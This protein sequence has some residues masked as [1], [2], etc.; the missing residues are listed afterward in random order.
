MAKDPP[1]AFDVS[2]TVEFPSQEVRRTFPIPFLGTGHVAPPLETERHCSLGIHILPW[3]SFI[4]RWLLGLKPTEDLT[5]AIAV[6]GVAVTFL[7]ATRARPSALVWIFFVS[8]IRGSS[9][10][11]VET[12]RYLSFVLGAQVS[13]E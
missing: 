2:R 5:A 13:K 4:R 8:V 12:S 1:Q 3:A 6:V 7:Q 9:H 11:L 10:S